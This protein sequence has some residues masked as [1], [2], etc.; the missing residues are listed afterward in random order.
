MFIIMFKGT[1]NVISSDPLYK[2]DNAQFITI[3]LY[4]V[5]DQEWT[6]CNV[7]LFKTD[8]LQLWFLY[9]SYMFIS[10][11][12]ERIWIIRIIQCFKT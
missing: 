3:T 8:Y 9:K 6:R 12:E 4:A 1:V 5:S 2:D 7:L 10:T 11:E